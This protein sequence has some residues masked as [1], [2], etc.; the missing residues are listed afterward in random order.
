[1]YFSRLFPQ[2]CCYL[3]E[4]IYWLFYSFICIS[5]VIPLP[6]FPSANSL[7]HPPPPVFMRVL[8]LTHSCLT[9]L[10]FPYAVA[11]SLPKTKGLPSH[12][13]P[14]RYRQLIS[15]PTVLL[16][17]SFP[18]LILPIFFLLLHSPSQ[19]PFS[20]YI[21]W[22]FCSSFY[23]G[24]KYP[25]FGLPFKLHTYGCGLHHRYSELLG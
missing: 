6:I 12:L 11:L 2:E 16:F 9:A 24:L 19:V 15:W 1:M 21:L 25:H 18:Y 13:C 20:L 14:L 3:I 8:P 17:Y 10:V 23:V 4:K 22:L 5:N 7:S